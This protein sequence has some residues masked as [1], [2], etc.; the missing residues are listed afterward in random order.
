MPA[1]RWIPA[2]LV[3]LVV[4]LALGAV[5]CSDETE[6]ATAPT[7]A[8]DDTSDA[9]A[10]VATA[11]EAVLGD[12]PFRSRV[13]GSIPFLGTDTTTVYEQSG[14]ET[15]AIDVR[16]AFTLAVAMVDEVVHE[17]DPYGGTWRATPLDEY[18]PFPGPET[19]FGMAL[20][21]FY[22]LAGEVPETV[23]PSAAW[24]PEILAGWTE[25]DGGPDGVRR[26]ERPLDAKLFTDPGTSEDADDVPG[27]WAQRRAVEDEY[28]RHAATTLVVELDA[29]LAL[30]R[31]V[32]RFEYDGSPDHPECEPLA[33]VVG[34]TEQ[35]VEFSDIG[36]DF[37][38]TVPEPA[39]MLAE[40]PTSDD[41]LDVDELTGL[42][43]QDLTGCPAA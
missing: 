28:F 29:D 17:W 18:D 21:F 10:L 36:A 9:D 23:D 43:E 20:M 5:A 25:V 11:F 15:L 34:T 27:H 1:R 38:I 6:V 14:G 42:L 40:Y 24:Q 13:S 35:I 33:E 22:D 31:L 3:A 2:P 30:S 16:E 8:P 7:T 19:S 4:L 32:V 12:G 39:E 26:F 37:T 41:A